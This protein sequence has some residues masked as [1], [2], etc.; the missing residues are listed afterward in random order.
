MF[1][2]H[3]SPTSPNLSPTTK[4]TSDNKSKLHPNAEPIIK[5]LNLIGITA[6]LTALACLFLPFMTLST[7]KTTTN[8]AFI[9]HPQY[10]LFIIPITLTACLYL[11]RQQRIA[12]IV[13][14]I[15]FVLLIYEAVPIVKL[16]RNLEVYTPYVSGNLTYSFYLLIVSSLIMVL[17]PF[18]HK[19]IMKSN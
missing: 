15:N 12:Y 13:S 7:L 5:P 11:L 2:F 10:K 18:I 19:T 4:A 6:S 1:K 3:N 17:A 14:T 9:H 16:S 8:Y